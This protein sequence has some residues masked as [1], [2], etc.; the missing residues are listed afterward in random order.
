MNSSLPNRE[1]SRPV[2][3]LIVHGGITTHGGVGESL[4]K[5]VI[6]QLPAYGLSVQPDAVVGE[7]V[8]DNR[9]WHPE[10]LYV[11]DATRNSI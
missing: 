3:H 2:T 4:V 8:I 10:Q 11:Q 1:I 7:V 5:G 6:K 9:G